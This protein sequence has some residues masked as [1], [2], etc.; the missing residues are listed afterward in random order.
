MLK[1]RWLSL[2]QLKFHKTHLSQDELE[3]LAEGRAASLPALKHLA[4]GQQMTDPDTLQILSHPTW[5]SLTSLDLSSGEYQ[6]VS[7]DAVLAS[8]RHLA[9]SNLPELIA[10]DISDITVTAPAMAQLA[11]KVW[12]LLR[13]LHIGASRVPRDNLVT[14]LPELTAAPWTSLQHLSL[15]GEILGLDDVR[16]LQQAWPHLTKLD[17]YS[18]QHYGD[19]VEEWDPNVEAWI[20]SWCRHVAAG[21]WPQLAVLDLGCNYFTADSMAELAKGY[22]PALKKLNLSHSSGDFL[23][24]LASAPW[25]ALEELDLRSCELTQHDMQ[26]LQ[27]AHY[28][29]LSVLDFHSAR[30][31]DA[32]HDRVTFY[33]MW[34]LAQQQW[35]LVKFRTGLTSEFYYMALTGWHTLRWLD[36]TNSP[37]SPEQV[38]TLL[39]ARGH[40]LETLHANC[41]AGAATKAKPEVN[42]WP[43]NT[44]MSLEVN[45]DSATVQ[46]LSV[47]YWPTFRIKC[48]NYTNCRQAACAMT[49]MLRLELSSVQELDMSGSFSG[50][51]DCEQHRGCSGFRA[52]PKA[53]KPEMSARPT[54]LNPMFQG[55]EMLPQALWWKLRRVNLSHNGLTEEFVSPI[56]GSRWP[57]LE[58][59]D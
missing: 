16:H 51:C 27:H 7:A 25:T 57:L 55:F 37:L 45:L 13:S 42:H 1:H 40:N 31:E 10:L 54:A 5:S 8:C 20:V 21:K 30:F 2:T 39:Q 12:P 36:V 33:K 32:E 46:S 47:G 44:Y 9:A 59:L 4:I 24:Q 18:C 11:T 34:E 23:A 19:Y 17:L 38:V 56:V 3:L 49:H 35:P 22:W 48:V 41:I 50:C 43:V 28:P 15:R 14:F 58:T 6:Q 26:H 52:G 53:H 29:R